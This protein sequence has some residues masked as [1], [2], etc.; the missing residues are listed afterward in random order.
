MRLTTDD[1]RLTEETDEGHFVNRRSYIVNS[2]LALHPVQRALSCQRC[3][4]A[5]E[6]CAVVEKIDRVALRLDV[7]EEARM[8]QIAPAMSLRRP[9]LE[10][11]EEDQLTSAIL[12]A[13]ATK[14]FAH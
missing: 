5:D 14:A 9:C 4:G 3:L 11:I 12:I 6:Q 7:A 2:R 10:R 8:L 1:R 13:A